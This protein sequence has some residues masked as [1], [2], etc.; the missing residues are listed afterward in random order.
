MITVVVTVHNPLDNILKTLNSI[1]T[2]GSNDKTIII[3][4]IPEEY[5][6]ESSVVLDTIE[7]FENKLP[8]CI[9]VK[10]LPG[11]PLAYA[12]NEILPEIN[13]PYVQFVRAGDC[14]VKDALHKT[15]Q[16]LEHHKKNADAAFMTRQR[17]RQNKIQGKNR[18]VDLKKCDEALPYEFHSVIFK[19]DVIQQ[20]GF[21]KDIPFDAMFDTL[22]KILLRKMKVCFARGAVI[23]TDEPPLSNTN[24]FRD[25]LYKEWY[26]DSLENFSLALFDYAKK[27]V[28][29][30]PIFIQQFLYYGLKLKFFHNENNNNHHVIDDSTDSFFSLCH[31]V[32]MQIEDNVILNRFYTSYND[33]SQILKNVFLKLKYKDNYKINYV[34]GPANILM[35]M[36]N[37]MLFNSLAQPVRFDIVEYEN[38]QLQINASIVGVFDFDVCNLKITFDERPV[39]YEEV[40]RYAHT[41]FFGL[42]ASKRY[43]FRFA[44]SK[45]KM[46]AAKRGGLL[47]FFICYNGIESQCKIT[48]DGYT[49]KISSLTTF[50]YW[51]FDE[52]TLGWDTEKS[53]SIKKRKRSVSLFKELM[54]L[55]RTLLEPQIGYKM[56]I[57]RCAY[58][59]YY[60]FLHNKNI[61]ITYDKL[62]K[63]GDCGEYIYKYAQG[64]D[65]DIIVDYVI[66]RN[67]ADRKRLQIEGY[68]PLIFGTLK[69]KMHYLFSSVVLNTHAGT[70]S[71]CS[72]SNN[73]VPFVQGLIKSNAMCIQHGLTVQ[74]LAFEENQ[75]HNNTKK[76]FCASKYEIKNLSH[77]IY[78]YFD[79]KCLRLTGIPRYDGLINND[80]KQILITPTWR[81]YI[82]MP[83]VMGQSRPYNPHFKETDYF[84][85]YNNL[86]A[87]QQLIDTANEYGYKLIY[88]LHPVISSQLVDYTVNEGVEIIPATEVNYEKI[89]TE[90]SLMVT[91]YSGVQ[92]DFAYMKKPVVYLHPPELPPHYKEGGFFYETMG[93]GEICTETE[94]L[95]TVLCDYMK[96]GCSMT[97]QYL[98]RVNDF[99]AFNDHNNCQRIYDEVKAYQQKNKA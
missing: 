38:E 63:G 55:A 65:K 46:L 58:W 11:T 1:Y 31:K 99:Y 98:D 26:H 37:H 21:R 69:Q 34:T 43:T 3:N 91:D 30:I 66:N 33:T 48:T 12:L 28:G 87:N 90:S 86:I 51:N 40:Y 14:Y 67:C 74:Q 62:Y 77:P 81:N 17:E 22:C 85:I 9:S 93:F 29:Y 64:K 7:A 92:F 6:N 71:F 88:L 60:P 84:K 53:L 83:S 89:L 50:S 10:T 16:Y 70:H 47:K 94:T 44:L 59:L 25:C 35:C 32:L 5:K 19:T 82:S 52:F 96:R 54:F 18:L 23:R 27:E 24:S 8:N 20:V 2:K 42:S 97:Q 72:F 76:Y 57:I 41:K 36:D 79:K 75:A 15:I 56:F 73:S 78:G 49:S 68:R 4:A 80:Q 61:W 13:T 39:K 95:V 45:K